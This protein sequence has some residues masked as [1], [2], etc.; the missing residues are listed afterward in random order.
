MHRTLRDHLAVT[1]ALKA[2]GYRYYHISNWWTPTTTNVDAD[3]VF[4]YEGQDEFSTVLAHDP[5]ARLHRA[6]VGPKDPW[7]WDV[8]REHTLYELNALDEVPSRLARSSPSPT[9]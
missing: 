1:T 7:D 6:G 9:C 5:A 2:L 4:H 8:L 3:R